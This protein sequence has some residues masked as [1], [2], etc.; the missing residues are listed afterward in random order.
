MAMKHGGS[1]EIPRSPPRDRVAKHEVML[2]LIHATWCLYVICGLPRGAID[3]GAQITAATWP[4]DLSLVPRN[5][6]QARMVLARSRWQLISAAL[7]KWRL[8]LESRPSLPDAIHA[9]AD[10]VD[11]AKQAIREKP[12]EFARLHPVDIWANLVVHL[13]ADGD[14]PAVL[15]A[16]AELRLSLANSDRRQLEDAV[17]RSTRAQAKAV[18]FAV[19]ARTER[20]RQRQVKVLAAANRAIDA[21]RPLRSLAKYIAPEL[22]VSASTVRRILREAGFPRARGR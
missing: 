2:P 20:A 4:G 7:A 3:D 19:T 14:W 18:S 15:R 11:F 21:G 8:D 10:V 6:R 22:D 12:P 1:G 5:A 13:M 9:Y 17:S 16:D